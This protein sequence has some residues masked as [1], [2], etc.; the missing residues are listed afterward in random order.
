MTWYQVADLARAKGAPEHLVP[1]IVGIVGAE[2]SFDPGAYN[3]RGENSY[4]LTQINAD[5]HGPKAR[6]ALGNPDRA[7][8]L[9]RDISGG[10]KNFT[11]WSVY[12]NGTYRSYMQPGSVGAGGGPGVAVPGLTENMSRGVTPLSSGAAPGAAD[13]RPRGLA[14]PLDRGDR[15][16][17]GRR[18]T[19]ASSSWMPLIAAGAGMLASRSPY[20][21]VALGEGL[22]TGVKS[23]G[24][25]DEREIKAQQAEVRAQRVEDQARNMG[26]LA[27]NAQQRL[28]MQQ[29]FGSDRIAMQAE[30]LQARSAERQAALAKD[31]AVLDE[32]M[33]SNRANEEERERY[34]RALAE[35]EKLRREAE[36]AIQVPGEHDGRPGT[37]LVD[38]KNP[39]DESKRHFIPGGPKQTG[40]LTALAYSQEIAKMIT[41][42]D[43]AG[44]DPSGAARKARRALEAAGIRPP[45]G[46]QRAAPAAQPASP[47]VTQPTPGTAGAP[48][49]ARGSSVGANG[50][51][52][53]T[54]GKSWFN[55]DHTPYQ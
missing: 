49:W 8:E 2:S 52:I 29:K 25:Q 26:T 18:D 35:T 42:L 7:M 36:A 38:R 46:A 50:V 55:A 19:W 40:E 43:P 54:D 20:P 6:E 53:Y 11:P 51:T 45:G 32:K 22:L 16:P 15:E 34:H 24:Q 28:E 47:G 5:A 13:Q 41:Q 21:G 39:G 10:W 14:E 17:R 44:L 9:M 4:G 1:T 12:K 33:R 37:W 48:A 30:T 23:A 27:A 31:M 3:G